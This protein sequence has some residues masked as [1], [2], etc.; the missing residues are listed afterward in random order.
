MYLPSSSAI[1]AYCCAIRKVVWACVCVLT[2]GNLVGEESF[3]CA[4]VWVP[5][6]CLILCHISGG[7]DRQAAD[8]V[9]VP[10]WTNYPS[11]SSITYFT[12]KISLVETGRRKIHCLCL[13][14]SLKVAGAYFI[15]KLN[16]MKTTYNQFE[17]YGA[18]KVVCKK[19]KKKRG[20]NKKS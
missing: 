3:S 6:T 13:S 8:W 4:C 5:V 16:Y 2:R 18:L 15:W 20:S 1:V 12:Q 9:S 7:V 17:L 14:A 11:V 19:K 10:F